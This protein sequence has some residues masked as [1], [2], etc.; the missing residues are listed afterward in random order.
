MNIASYQKFQ[1][2]HYKTK[3]ASRY[4][5]FM[6]IPKSP[7]KNLPMLNVQEYVSNK[8]PDKSYPKQEVR[9]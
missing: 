8:P 6:R 2:R 9:K 5:N 7:M 4:K 1:I 3:Y